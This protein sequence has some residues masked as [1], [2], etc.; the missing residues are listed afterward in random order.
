[1]KRGD[2]ATNRPSYIVDTHA[3][4]WNLQNPGRLSAAAD[5]IFRLAEAGAAKIIIPAI[6]I[7]EFYY[8]AKKQNQS[9]SLPKLIDDIE[10]T[11]CFALSPLGRD[12][13]GYFEVLDDV[14]EMHD[15]LIAAEALAQNAVVVS[16][17]KVI[18]S[19]AAV[20]TVW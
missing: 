7:A 3:L 9:L 11:A 13:L 6:V 10:N 8:V 17:D 12:Q 5:A 1:M 19:S 4:Y 15:R 20:V 18:A 16:K 2:A 14:D